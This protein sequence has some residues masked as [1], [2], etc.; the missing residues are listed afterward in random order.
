[1]CFGIQPRLHRRLPTSRYFVEISLEFC[2][3]LFAEIRSLYDVSVWKRALLSNSTPSTPICLRSQ[4]QEP[5]EWEGRPNKQTN[6]QTHTL[7]T[8][9][10]LVY[11][12]GTIN[13]PSLHAWYT[14]PL[15]LYAWYTQPPN[16]HTWYTQPHSL[17]TW[18]S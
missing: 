3:F 17:H 18:Y 2:L 8:L 7:G 14:Q 15:S 11:I 12:L 16:L 1:M 4:K 10:P 9:N 13:P 5:L 6:K